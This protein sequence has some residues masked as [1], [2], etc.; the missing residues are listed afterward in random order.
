MMTAKDRADWGDGARDDAGFPVTAPGTTTSDTTATGKQHFDVLDGLRGAA[1]MLVVLFHIQGITV[2]WDGAK[3]FFHHAPLAVDFFFALSGFVIGYAYDDR[4]ARLTPGRFLALRLIRLHPMVILGVVM[5]LISYLVDPYA[6][7]AQ[8]VSAGALTVA[9][10]MGLLVLP[11]WPLPNRWTDTHPLNGPCW[12]LFQEYL[13]NLAYAFVLRRLSTR[14]L[15]VLALISAVPL[16][17][18]AE[19]F[20]TLDLGSAWDHGWAAPMRLCFPFVTGL[21]LYR[22]RARLPAISLGFLPLTLVLVVAVIC[23]ILPVVGGI[24]LNG[25]YE[26]ACVIV[27]F[28]LVILAGAH[29]RAGPGMQGLCRVSGRL[30]YP[31]YVTHFPFLYVWMNY[32]AN[33]HPST[34][35]ML[36]IGALLVPMLILVAWLSLRLWDEPVRARLR[37][38]LGR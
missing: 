28:P 8:I 27:L 2:V 37:A 9:F 21:W 7:T 24:K 4:W 35:R 36:V 18:S 20:G 19:H 17:I 38:R 12:S 11:T 33:Q 3:I 34:E 30:S 26:A 29:S 1:A 14:A 10:V 23:P 16:V 5:G 22:M 15:G 6:G 13:G 31:I 25:L 32:V